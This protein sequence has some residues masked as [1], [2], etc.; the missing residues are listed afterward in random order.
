[1]D[2][3]R[4]RRVESALFVLFASLTFAVS[5][6]LAR[7][8]RP[9]DPLLIAFGRLALAALLLVVIEARALRPALVGLT[10]RQRLTV[11]GAGAL[12]AG[13]FACFQ[14][15][16]DRTSLPAALSLVSLEP[17]SVVLCA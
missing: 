3:A 2:P 6:P 17:L 13:H 16:L 1:M 14:I 4:K 7:W 5:G 8:A 9:T 11:L 10:S 15:G 12:L